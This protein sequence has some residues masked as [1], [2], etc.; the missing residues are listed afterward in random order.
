MNDAEGDGMV[1]TKEQ[2]EEALRVQQFARRVS[3][4]LLSTLEKQWGEQKLESAVGVLTLLHAI[5]RLYGRY[6][7]PELN[8]VE[9]WE[10]LSDDEHFDI[11]FDGYE[12]EK[13]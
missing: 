8:L 3:T 4:Q 12:Q 5:G 2:E 13:S 11:I 10:S 7:R 9:L 6:G 1:L